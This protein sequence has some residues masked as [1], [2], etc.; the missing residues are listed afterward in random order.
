VAAQQKLCVLQACYGVPVYCY[1][2]DYW[3]YDIACMLNIDHVA[4]A[5]I[6]PVYSNASAPAARRR[7][8]LQPD[9]A[10]DD[11]I[12]EDDLQQVIKQ[13]ATWGMSYTWAN[14]SQECSIAAQTSVGCCEHSS[15][16]ALSDDLHD[17]A[18]KPSLLDALLHLC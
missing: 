16:G 9:D 13:T 14:L 2:T 5:G 12:E 6:D 18:T 10:D 11:A 1:D 15:V 8:D 7:V 3:P 17:A 4:L